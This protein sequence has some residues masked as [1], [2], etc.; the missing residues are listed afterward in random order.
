MKVDET[1][2]KDIAKE[3]EKNNFSELEAKLIS[4]MFVMGLLSI[5][6]LKKYLPHV[7]VKPS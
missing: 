6:Q 2:I 4:P 5:Q 3:I 7:D 1:L